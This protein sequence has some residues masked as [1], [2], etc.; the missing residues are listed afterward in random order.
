MTILENAQHTL[1]TKD[2]SS[3]KEEFKFSGV[4]LINENKL[5]IGL[6]VNSN[7]IEAIETR[8]YVQVEQKDYV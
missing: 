7:D 8:H 5:T 4:L 1:Y 3:E 6:V 2:T